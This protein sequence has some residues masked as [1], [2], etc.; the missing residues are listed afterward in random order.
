MNVNYADFIDF[1]RRANLLSAQLERIDKLT[2]KKP[3][4]KRKILPVSRIKMAIGALT[5]GKD[6]YCRSSKPCSSKI[7]F[8]ASRGKR[9]YRVC[10]FSGCCSM[11]TFERDLGLVDGG[12]FC[13][14]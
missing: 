11:R 5:N 8:R 9:H 7:V 6:I 3:K 12:C 13:V 1:K 2:A 14:A 4:K 10:S